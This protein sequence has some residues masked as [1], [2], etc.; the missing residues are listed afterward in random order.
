MSLFTNEVNVDNTV[1]VDGSAVTQPV[2]AVSLPLP[3]GAATNASVVALTKPSDTQL[4]DGSAHTQPVSGTFW[5]AT[6]PVSVASPVAVTQSTS[7]WVVSG[8]V[9]TSSPASNSD[10]V[11]QVT[12]TG[13]NQTILAANA[14]R[15]KAILFFESGIWHVKFG[16]TASASSKTY[17]VTASN[18]TIEIPV[19]VGQIDAL[20]TT[21]GKLVDVT[22]MI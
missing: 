5:Q 16:A 11:T 21:S 1:L 10:T 7:P 22:E 4:V 13:S 6:Q 20:C 8:T 17:M 14:S 2:S 9:T 18:T 15:K 3:T 19:W 12:S